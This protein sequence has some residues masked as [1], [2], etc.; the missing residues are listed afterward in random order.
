[1]GNIAGDEDVL[2]RDRLLDADVVDHIGQLFAQIPG[3][4]WDSHG[5]TEV[6]RTLTWLM[7]C[8]CAGTPAPKLAE[9][10]CAFDYFAQV[11]TGTDDTEMLSEALWGLHHLLNG[12]VS[13]D[14]S[15]ARAARMLSA[16]FGPEEL[17]W[18]PKGGTDSAEALPHPVVVQ[19]VNCLGHRGDH[20]SSTLDPAIKILGCLVST[21]CI[22]FTDV[23]IGAGALKAL[24][25]ILGN[26]KHSAKVRENA[27]WILSN[28]AAGSAAQAQKLLDDPGTYNALQAGLQRGPSQ[29][30][31]REC[32]WALA[33]LVRQGAPVL[34]RIDCRELLRV[35]STAL[36]TA[37]DPALQS[38]LLDAAEATLGQAALKGIAEN[39]LVEAAEGFGL[40]DSLEELQHAESDIIYRKAVHM[41]EAHFGVDG[42]NE[43]PI[44]PPARQQQAYKSSTAMPLGVRGNSPSRPGYMFGA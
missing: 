9:V 27:A 41:L 16:G 28:I 26:V 6:L 1:L 37:T 43:A 39:P 22:D 12:A 36:A 29:E 17:P 40:L 3:F 21:S 23:V 5:R 15:D 18:P 19:V 34:S 2:L 14:D 8:L 33:N 13:E 31:R 24:R 30:V 20:R 42:E 25:R 38:T 44:M 10:D 35:V 4:T 11:V 32:A 7:S